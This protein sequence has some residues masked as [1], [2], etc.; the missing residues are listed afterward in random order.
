MAF[1]IKKWWQPDQIIV[2]PLVLSPT[3]VVH[4]MPNQSPTTLNVPPCLLS[5]VALNT[6]S[7]VRNLLT[8]AVHLYDEDADNTDFASLPYL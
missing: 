6:C 1:D 5:Q 8:D 7:K 3:A 2:T 4:N